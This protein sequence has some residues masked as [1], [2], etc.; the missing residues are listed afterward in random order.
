MQHGNLNLRY[1][2]RLSDH[3][4]VSFQVSLLLRAEDHIPDMADIAGVSGL[5]RLLAALPEA[6]APQPHEEGRRDR[7][8]DGQGTGK[9]K[10]EFEIQ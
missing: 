10:I 4:C 2:K 1:I 5:A 8:L 7:P 6:R 3:H 9:A